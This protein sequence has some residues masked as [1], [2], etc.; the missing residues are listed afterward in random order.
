MQVPELAT[1]FLLGTNSLLLNDANASEIK[2]GEYW[3]PQVAPCLFPI[4][5]P[6]LKQLSIRAFD[7]FHH[8]FGDQK[9]LCAH[10]PSLRMNCMRSTCGNIPNHNPVRQKLVTDACVW[11]NAQSFVKRAK[12]DCA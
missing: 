9:F 2:L 11:S 1:C 8:L 6:S 12:V 10:S 3:L 7:N 4:F 5:A